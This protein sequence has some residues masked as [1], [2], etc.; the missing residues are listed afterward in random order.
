[1]AYPAATNRDVEFF[2]EHGW[3]SVADAIDP[4]DLGVLTARCDEILSK[5]ESMAFDWAWEKGT[6][7][8][9]REFKIVQASPTQHWPE[10]NQSRFRLWAIDF[11]TRLMGQPLEFWYDQFLAK[12]PGNSA[13]TLWH[14]DEGYW[15]RNL[16]E[17]GITCWMPFHDVDV[18]NGCM[19]FIDGGHKL[20]VLAHRQPDNIQS[21]LLT[22]DPPTDADVVPCPIKLG[23]VTF[24]H[25]KTPHMTPANT[26]AEWRRILTQHLRVVGSKGEGDH[27]PWKVYV[28]Q[29]TGERYVPKSR[30]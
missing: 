19:H 26:T 29:F 4:A 25:G 9:Q 10:L 15:G 7:R 6:P 3:I 22:C 21:D 28:N 14:Q 24:H 30:R 1:M 16:D 13:P 20:G 12:P 17:R 18:A 2:A 11:A 27:Y 23:S 5:K 8:E